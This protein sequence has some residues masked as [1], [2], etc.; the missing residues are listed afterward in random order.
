MQVQRWVETKM[1]IDLLVVYCYLCAIMGT[2]SPDFYISYRLSAMSNEPESRRRGNTLRQYFALMP[3]FT[4]F[5]RVFGKHETKNFNLRMM[6]GINKISILLFL[7]ALIVW[8][9][10]RLFF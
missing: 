4:Y 1:L 9:C 2:K 10:K 3:V 7:F 8:T 5:F 6:H